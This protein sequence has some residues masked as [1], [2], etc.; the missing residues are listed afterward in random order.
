MGTAQIDAKRKA[1]IML[2]NNPP[3]TAAAVEQAQIVQDNS[4]KVRSDL[5]YVL[6]KGKIMEIIL[7]TAINTDQAGEIRGIVARDVFAEDHKTRLIPKGSKIFGTFSNTVD[8]VYGILKVT[9]T[10]IDLASGYTLQLTSANSVDNLGRTGIIGRLDNKYK[11]QIVQNAVSSA[12]SIGLAQMTDKLITASINTVGAQKYGSLAS[13]LSTLN[14]TFVSKMAPLIAEATTSGDTSALQEIVNT[15]QTARGYFFD[16]TTSVYTTLDTSCNSVTNS[17]AAVT[18]H[19]AS[20]MTTISN[21]LQTASSSA[22]SMA[23]SNT[24][25]TLT[26]TQ[27]AVKTAIQSLTNQV[28]SFNSN[29]TYSPNIT[30]SQ[31]ELIRVLIDQDYTFPAKA[32]GSFTSVLQ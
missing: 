31:G 10:R 12:L 21:A 27:S 25:D 19:Y 4:F 6:G 24:S 14:T 17:T 32:V 9:W 13:S 16:Q 11:E 20:A 5:K 22:S 15:C 29:K 8:Q 3:K 2:I 30:I 7:E 26:S 23:N 1:N 18:D 28:Q